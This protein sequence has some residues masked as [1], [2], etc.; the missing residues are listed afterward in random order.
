MV[1]GRPTKLT[2]EIQN[3]IVVLIRAGNYVET[4]AASAGIHKSTLY[5]WLKRG[6]REKQRITQNPRARISKKEAPFVDFSDAVEKAQAEAESRDVMLIAK[7]AEE[8]WQA[9]AWRLERKFPA[10]WGRKLDVKQ[11]VQGQVKV[12]HDRQEIVETI[13]DTPELADLIAERFR[14]RAREGASE[15]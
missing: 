7:A 2:P 5:D 9:A 3:R 12:S 6:A 15:A 14:Q 11:E 4:A 1:V 13:V 10:R 8:Q